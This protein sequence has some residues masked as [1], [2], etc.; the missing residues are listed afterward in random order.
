M[1]VPLYIKFGFIWIV[2]FLPGFKLVKYPGTEAGGWVG[3]GGGGG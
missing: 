2:G 1:E 3:V